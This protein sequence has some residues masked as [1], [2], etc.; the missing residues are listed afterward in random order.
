MAVILH[1]GVAIH[2]A[3]ASGD[4]A[5]MKEEAKEAEEFLRQTGDVS[6]ALERLKIEI[7]RLEAGKG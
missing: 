7:A 1:Y 3:I 2:N 6:A 5:R 4:L